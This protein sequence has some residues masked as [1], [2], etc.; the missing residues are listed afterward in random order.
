MQTIHNQDAF[1]SRQEQ[2]QVTV[3]MNSLMKQL[4]EES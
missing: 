4:M 2:F 3:K 1:N